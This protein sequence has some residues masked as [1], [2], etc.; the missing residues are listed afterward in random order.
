MTLSYSDV[1][2]ILKAIDQSHADHVEIEIEGLRIAVQ[3]RGSGVSPITSATAQSPPSAEL[4]KPERYLEAETQDSLPPSPTDKMVA[5][6]G[7]EIIRS[8][9]VGTF[10]RRPSPEQPA[11][12]D[13]GSVIK[14]GDPLCL[15][16]VMKLYSTIEA[17]TGGTIISI[18]AEDG[19]LVEFDQ[20]LFLIK[21]P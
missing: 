18:F 6:Q 21:L 12:V 1:A 15:I 19:N 17:T 9:M 16:E 4:D 20:Q 14:E 7:H 5:P 8:P 13:T 11:F 10:Y 3:R 2:E